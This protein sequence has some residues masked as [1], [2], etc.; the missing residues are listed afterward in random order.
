LYD[1][2]AALFGERTSVNL[3]SAGFISLLQREKGDHEV[4][5]EVFAVK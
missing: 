5:D 3:P 4:V 2:Y 1:K